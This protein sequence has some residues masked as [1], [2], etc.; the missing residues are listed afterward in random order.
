MADG[1]RRAASTA[2]PET[3][4]TTS[5]T[6]FGVTTTARCSEPA[7]SPRPIEATVTRDDASRGVQRA[8]EAEAPWPDARRAPGSTRGG[9]PYADVGAL[10]TVAEVAAGSLS[11]RRARAGAG[12]APA[13]GAGRCRPRRRPL[14][15]RAGRRPARRRRRRGPVAAGN[16]AYEERFDRVFLIRAA[17]RSGDEILAELTRRL[18]NDDET[19]RV[20]TVQQ[21]REIALLRLEQVVDDVATLST[22]VLDTA[23]GRPASGVPVTLSKATVRCSPR[24]RPT[25]TVGWHR[26]AVTSPRATT[27][28]ASRPA[29]RSTPRSW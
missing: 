7:H 19:E 4:T 26:S 21:L 3:G 13:H 27:G 1:P 18:D 20:E 2:V 5:S 29:G 15:T 10:L 17:G 14:G 28:S 11:E 23:A 8:T 9:R 22:H 25:T 24:P 16:R 12:S 6:P